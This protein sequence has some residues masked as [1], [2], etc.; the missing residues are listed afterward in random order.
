M[1][2]ITMCNDDRCP[3]AG[4]CYRFTAP[5]SDYN[6]SWFMITPLNIDKSCDEFLLDERHKILRSNNG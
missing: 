4:K 6:Q 1:A 3:R 2:D 5:V